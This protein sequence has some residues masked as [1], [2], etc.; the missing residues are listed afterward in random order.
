MENWI[1]SEILDSLGLEKFIGKIYCIN[2]WFRNKNNRAMTKEDF[3]SISENDFMCIRGLGKISIEKLL[4]LQ[5]RLRGDLE[6]DRYPKKEDSAEV[7]IL[8][9]RI[10]NHKTKENELRKKIE[11]LENKISEMKKENKELKKIN[12]TIE[13]LKE[14]LL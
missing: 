12:A 7:M 5:R 2:R 13:K 4:W 14:V 8:K 10:E 9:I 11:F 3:L 1:S 6:E